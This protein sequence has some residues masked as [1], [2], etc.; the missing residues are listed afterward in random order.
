MSE[1]VILR[2]SDL[3]T[4]FFTK[5]G[6]V[7]AV[8]SLSLAVTAG[9]VFGIVGESGS[10]KSVTARSII[11]LI[12]SPGKITSGTIE[13]RDADLAERLREDYPDAVDGEFVDLLEIPESIH[14]SL[15]GPKFSMIFQDRESSFNPKI[16]RAHV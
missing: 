2:I 6:Q 7:N 10:G 1:D 15:R 12:E 11:R 16:G 8:E 9:E 3:C 13:Y 14:R 4:R 5:A